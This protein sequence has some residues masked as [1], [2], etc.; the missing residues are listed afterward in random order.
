LNLLLEDLTKNVQEYL[1]QEYHSVFN[2]I[3]VRDLTTDDSQWSWWI[4]LIDVLCDLPYPEQY[5]SKLINSLKRYYLGN[6][7]Q[8][9]VIDEFERDYM[10]SKAIWWYT[11]D[12]FLYRLLNKTLR[13]H[14][15]KL[16]FLFGFLV[17]DIYRQLTDEHEI[18]KLTHST[19]TLYRGQ[20]M[21]SVEITD[22][23]EGYKW[24]VNNSFFSTSLDRSVALSFLNR[25]L[26]P[27]NSEFQ[28]VLFEIE[29]DVRQPSPRPYAGVSHLSEFANETE[30]IFMYGT[31]F[32]RGNAFYDDNENIWIVKLELIHNKGDIDLKS[33]KRRKTLCECIQLLPSHIWMAPLEDQEII[34]NELIH[35]YPS[36]R[37]LTAAKLS[38]LAQRQSF[39]TALSNYEQAFKILI[40]YTNDHEL[41]DT[42]SIYHIIRDIADWCRY[43]LKIDNQINVKHAEEIVETILKYCAASVVGSCFDAIAD[44]YNRMSKYDDALINYEKAIQLY[45][46]HDS[47]EDRYAITRIYPKVVKIYTEQK[48]DHHSALK[49]QLIQ[50][51]HALKVSEDFYNYSSGNTK[52]ESVADS[53]AQLGDIYNALKRYNLANEHYTHAVKLYQEIQFERVQKKIPAIEQKMKTL[54]TF[55]A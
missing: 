43:K 46:R 26:S 14:N 12:T 18:F 6:T 55:L 54:Q 38:F 27:N 44:L 7:V 24:I 17:Q 47:Q 41:K 5:R 40:E 31:E 11:R 16:I 23:R 21:S 37:W 25:T 33:A 4:P 49:F 35:L 34:F 28:N 19:L 8:T 45:M 36:Q 53:H 20:T 2:P 15:I 51:D 30:I 48:Q 29:I 9:D 10:P 1:K 22:L 39:N 52:K 42:I 3:G 13:Q 50:H 32:K